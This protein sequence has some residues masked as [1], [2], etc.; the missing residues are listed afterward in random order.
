MWESL[1]ASEGSV[2][3]FFICSLSFFHAVTRFFTRCQASALSMLTKRMK[4]GTP[5]WLIL[6]VNALSNQLTH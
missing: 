2:T 3:P 6:F 4:F 1:A 5:L